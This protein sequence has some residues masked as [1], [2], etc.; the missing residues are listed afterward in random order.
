[1]EMQDSLLQFIYTIDR[2]Y[3][4]FF[5]NAPQLLGNATSTKIPFNPFLHDAR[6]RRNFATMSYSSEKPPVG[7]R[8]HVDALQSAAC[9][10]TPA[11]RTASPALGFI[12][13]RVEDTDPAGS[14]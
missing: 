14:V 13:F 12:V 8:Q 2:H 4:V 6:S 9:L 7:G 3:Q 10:A 1:M 5:L 11:L